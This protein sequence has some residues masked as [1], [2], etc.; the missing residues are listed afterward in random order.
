MPILRGQTTALI[1][2]IVRPDS[3]PYPPYF[4]PWNLR[5]CLIFLPP[6]RCLPLSG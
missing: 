4:K 3:R 5:M 1:A 6:Y 2:K